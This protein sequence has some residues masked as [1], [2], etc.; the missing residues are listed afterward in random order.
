[1]TDVSIIGSGM[2]RFGKFPERSLRDLSEEAV[3]AAL[4]DAGVDAARIDA[5]IVSNSVAGIVTGQESVRGQTVVRGLG[6]MGKPI[7]NV[8]N[9]CASGS[10]AFYFGRQGIRAGD[11]GTVLVLGVEKMAHP[12]RKVTYRALESAADISDLGELG[13]AESSIF[14]EIYAEKVKKYMKATG[15]TP[16]DFAW[17]VVKNHDHAA[18]NPFAQ[19]RNRVTEQE[20]LDS[21]EVA[22]PLTRYM[23]SPI[24]D[25]A[26]ALVLTSEPGG[27]HAGER[28][29]RVLGSGFSSGDPD[30]DNGEHHPG[31]ARAAHAAY[32]QAGI[33]PADVD[34]AEVHD[35]AAPAEME[36]YESLGFAAAGDGLRLVRERAT[37]LGGPLPVNTSG[38]LISR[39]HPVGV[40]GIAQLA[41]IVE[42][43]RGEAGERQVDGARIGVVQ[44]AGGDIGGVSAAS[45]VHVLG[46]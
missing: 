5:T 33:G 28:A 38:G 40:T 1:M 29:V 13:N 16:S 30:H 3:R 39:G 41:E 27:G 43:L 34:V 36:S 35:A 22:W 37:M 24:G 21:G 42:Q 20:V 6:L 25:G 7:F 19:Y 10:S 9:A 26:A 17:L 4:D 15:A 2:T 23:C 45:A 46:K 44:N 18:L 11:W 8:E 31:V 12:D 32:D 14:M